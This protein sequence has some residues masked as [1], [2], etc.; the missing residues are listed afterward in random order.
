MPN[1]TGLNATVISTNLLC[2]G[3]AS[4]E[5]D[6]PARQQIW[7]EHR[8]WAHGLLYFLANDPAVPEAFRREIGPWGL[9]RDE[10]EDTGHWPDQLYVREGRRMLG[11][12]VLT[13]H[14]LVSARARYDSTGMAA[15]NVDIREVQWVAKTVTRFPNVHKEVPMEGY[16][17]MSVEPYQIPCRSLM[18]QFGGSR[19]TAWTS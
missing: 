17:S 7:E 10:F 18:P 11:E 16:L 6:W 9:A 12:Y 3:R 4:I 15:Y 19:G 1:K 13:Q 2:A 5:T 14:D 8:N